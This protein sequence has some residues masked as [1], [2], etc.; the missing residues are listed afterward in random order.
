MEIMLEMV[1]AK[2][3]ETRMGSGNAED[4]DGDGDGVGEGD[5]KPGISTAAMS[6]YR[7]VPRRRSS[8]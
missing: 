5:G 2:V 7:G 3:M 6:L 8:S 4:G 1:S